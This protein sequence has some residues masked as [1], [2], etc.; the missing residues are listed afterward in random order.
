MS[1]LAVTTNAT[2]EQVASLE[3]QVATREAE[4]NAYK[5][6]LQHLQDRDA[7]ETAQEQSTV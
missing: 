4:L 2:R 7:G 3:L 5:T 6:D 1:T